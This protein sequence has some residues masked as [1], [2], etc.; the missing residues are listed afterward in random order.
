MEGVK[1]ACEAQIGENEH[2]KRIEMVDTWQGEVTKITD[3]E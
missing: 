2:W 3:T 1:N